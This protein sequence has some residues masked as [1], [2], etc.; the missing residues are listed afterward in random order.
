MARLL[1]PVRLTNRPPPKTRPA[2]RPTNFSPRK[3]L[4]ADSPR[5]PALASRTLSFEISISLLG[6]RDLA[7]AGEAAWSTLVMASVFFRAEEASAR[8]RGLRMLVEPFDRPGLAGGH[9]LQTR[10]RPGPRRRRRWQQRHQDFVAQQF[11][12]DHDRLRP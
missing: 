10:T 12:E 9:P 4:P 1:I 3:T 5:K 11:G 7:R 2:S 6:S 8:R